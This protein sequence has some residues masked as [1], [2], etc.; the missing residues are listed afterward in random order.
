LGN[1]RLDLSVELGQLSQ[2]SLTV[3]DG[4]DMSVRQIS[5]IEHDKSKITEK[6]NQLQTAL[7]KLRETK[8]NSK[9]VE[10]LAR[11]AQALADTTEKV[12][13]ERKWYEI[14][15]AGIVEAA[16]AIGDSSTPIVKTVLALMS[17]LKGVAP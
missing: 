14:S 17:L 3:G 13:R 1:S 9:H 4:L 15:T 16:K 8:G 11:E 12:V 7:E 10:T 5:I 6:L 2:M